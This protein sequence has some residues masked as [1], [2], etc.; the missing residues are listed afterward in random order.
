M[1]WNDQKMTEGMICSE[2]MDGVQ[3]RLPPNMPLWQIDY[4][5]LKFL[6][7]QSVGEH[8]FP[9]KQ[10][11]NLPC[12][13]ILC[14]PGWEEKSLSPETVKCKVSRPRRLPK[15]TVTPSLTCYPKQK[16][17]CFVQSSQIIASLSARYKSC[18]P[19]SLLWAL[20]VWGSRMDE[21]KFDCFSPVDLSFVNLILL[22]QPKRS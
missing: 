5:E 13:A 15:Q 19:W 1:V 12:E 8:L 22:D 17:L 11:I 4:F 6:G 3:G 21:I 14:V 18:L 10:E 16:A 9:W 2:G 7:E 20:Y